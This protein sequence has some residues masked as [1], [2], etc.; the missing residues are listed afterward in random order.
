VVKVG[1]RNFPVPENL[2]A[3]YTIGHFKTQLGNIL[4]PVTSG[5]EVKGETVSDDKKISELAASSTEVS[6]ELFLVFNIDKSAPGTSAVSPRADSASGGLQRAQSVQIKAGTGPITVDREL[7]TE[8]SLYLDSGT[9]YVTVT[10]KN[11]TQG[12]NYEG[13]WSVSESHL[14]ST[15]AKEMK[16][17]LPGFPKTSDRG[18]VKIGTTSKNIKDTDKLGALGVKGKKGDTVK[19]QFQFELPP[20]GGASSSAPA[21]AAPSEA[22]EPAP[23][24]DAKWRYHVTADVSLM[25]GNVFIVLNGKS[26]ADRDGGALPEARKS[27]A[28]PKMTFSVFKLNDLLN[29]IKGGMWPA[30]EPGWAVLKRGASER[31]KVNGSVSLEKAGILCPPTGTAHY[32][33]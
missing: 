30:F 18:T 26:E 29:V 28:L 7:A 25:E 19:Y 31:V 11:D 10:A 21:A 4:P 3:K 33:F 24:I 17:K 2:Y 20:V 15:S 5:A 23:D 16:S 8:V 22:F 9:V 32:E 1:Q 6:N 12:V 13:K 14:S 27:A